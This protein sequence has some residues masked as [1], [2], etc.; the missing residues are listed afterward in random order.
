MTIMAQDR[1]QGRADYQERMKQQREELKKT[2]ELKKDQ[3]EKFDKIYNDFDKKRQEMMES[4]RSGGGDRE[5]MRDKMT[6]M[7]TE[8]DEA[9]K[10]ILDKDQVKKYEAYLKKQEEDRAARANERRGGG[11]RR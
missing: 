3:A 2:L 9:L 7:N 10:K 1:G 8:R 11:G 4:M 5:G 6:K